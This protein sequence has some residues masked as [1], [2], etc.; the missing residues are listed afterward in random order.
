MK[1]EIKI[2]TERPHSTLLVVDGKV[3]GTLHQ[4]MFAQTGDGAPAMSVSQHDLGSPNET[5]WA[6]L[7][8]TG[9]AVGFDE[10]T[11]LGDTGGKTWGA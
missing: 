11:K 4:I 10:L 6:G 3:V 9:R 2:D 5:R 1:I 8:G 7:T